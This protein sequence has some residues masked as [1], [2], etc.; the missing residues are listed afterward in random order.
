M[1]WLVIAS[2]FFYAWWNPNP[3]SAWSPFYLLLILA[4]CGANFWCGKVIANASRPNQRFALLTAAVWA[5]LGLMLYYLLHFSADIGDKMTDRM[6]TPRA[7]PSDE[8]RFGV[9]VGLENVDSHLEAIREDHRRYCQTHV[10][11]VTWVCALLRQV[12]KP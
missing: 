8:A 5:N 6:L 9:R 11:N 4:S 1:G 2:L 10:D 3:A 12:V 7:D